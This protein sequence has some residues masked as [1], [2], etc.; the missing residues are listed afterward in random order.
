[1]T[2]CVLLVEDEDPIRC[3]SERAL[4]RAGWQVWSVGSA[5]AAL[6]RMQDQLYSGTLPGVLVADIALPGMDGPALIRNA[7]TLCPG[8]PAI[9]V[10][11]Y[12]ESMLSRDLATQNVGFL[13]KPFC[14]HE[15]VGCVE[16]AAA[17]GR[18]AQQEFVDCS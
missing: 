9:L 11:G 6:E 10:S 5:E 8:L 3:V 15:L 2:R 4:Q 16:A 7:R 12:A 1:M 14:T 18:T 17:C 13:R